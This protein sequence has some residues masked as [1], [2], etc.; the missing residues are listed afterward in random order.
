MCLNAITLNIQQNKNAQSSASFVSKTLKPPVEK[1]KRTPT[2]V[3]APPPLNPLVTPAS[4]PR[5]GRQL[6]V[7]GNGDMGQFGL[8]LDTLGDITRP[9]LH[10]WFEAAIKEGKLGE[11]VGA[12][13][14]RV[15]VGGMHSLIIDELG[16]VWSWG[17]VS[18]TLSERPNAIV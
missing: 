15:A 5:P 9:R 10:A 2:I 3:N 4:H 16:R 6:F 13:I 18:S 14:E 12:G 7:F 11:A 1:P 17:I 8:G